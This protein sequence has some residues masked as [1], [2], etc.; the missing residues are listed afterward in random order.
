MGLFFTTIMHEQNIHKIAQIGLAFEGELMAWE[1]EVE[2]G[3]VVGT[4]K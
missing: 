2:E 1:F 3:G 4:I